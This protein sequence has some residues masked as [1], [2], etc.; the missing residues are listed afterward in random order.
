M[1]YCLNKSAILI[2]I[3]LV[4]TLDGGLKAQ[5][6][7]SKILSLDE[8]IEIAVKNNHDLQLSE[9]EVDISKSRVREAKSSFYPHIETKIVL[10]LVERESGFFLDQLIWDFNRTSNRV[11]SSKFRLQANQ[12]S[13]DQTLRDTIQNVAVL[14]YEAL[15]NRS[16]LESARKN[17]EKNELILE[18]VAEQKKLNRSSNLDLARARFDAVNS[19]L[20]LLKKQN[21]YDKGKL[22]LLD[23]IGAEFASNVE[24]KDQ[25]QIEFRNYEL[26]ESLERAMKNN[27]ELKKLGASYSAQLAEIKISKSNFYPRIYGRTAYRFEGEAGE[28]DP[29]LIA[30]VGFNFPIFK[31]FSRFA[32]LNVSKAESTRALIRIEQAKKKIQLDIKELSMD[33]K[34][35]RKKIKLEKIKNKV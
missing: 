15:I 2:A 4:L 20:E 6:L 14:Y 34:F 31:G 1:S 10:P 23:V 29:D 16:L 17:M 11:K 7:S 9:L 24:L 32:K 3:F 35:K 22:E 21:E 28:G 8:A 26:K 19:K 5:E 27:L 13:H 25:E 33:M 12:Y 30:G 18:K